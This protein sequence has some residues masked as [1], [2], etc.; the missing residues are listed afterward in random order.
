MPHKLEPL[1]TGGNPWL[2]AVSGILGK[3]VRQ[4]IEQNTVVEICKQP[5]SE[6]LRRRLLPAED[7]SFPLARQSSVPNAP[8]SLI[9]PVT[10]A[11]HTNPHYLDWGVLLGTPHF[12]ALLAGSSLSLCRQ[13]LA[14]E[15]L[16]G[17]KGV[18]DV[19]AGS[20]GHAPFSPKAAPAKTLS[21]VLAT[22]TVTADTLHFYNEETTGAA[23]NSITSRLPICLMDHMGRRKGV[24]PINQK[25]GVTAHKIGELFLGSQA[26]DHPCLRNTRSAPRSIFFLRGGITDATKPASLTPFPICSHP[27]DSV[28]PSTSY[29]LLPESVT[30]HAPSCL[31]PGEGPERGQLCSDLGFFVKRGGSC[32]EVSQIINKAELDLFAM[33][34][35]RR[36]K[37][38]ASTRSRVVK[39][40]PHLLQTLGSRHRG[41]I[42]PQGEARYMWTF[43]PAAQDQMYSIVSVG[44]V[45]TDLM[46]CMPPTLLRPGSSR[47]GSMIDSSQVSH[48][49]SRLL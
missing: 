45:K 24:S 8:V 2:C 21:G 23:A 4:F 30:E 46:D 40:H 20:T 29:E 49:S 36:G 26:D 5:L 19:G 3:N 25:A 12:K 14:I 27:Y 44:S 7:S 17:R 47:Y 18:W 39:A 6:A 32:R 10:A 13:T 38:N 1:I 42:F 37:V 34:M 43:H 15:W 48:S 9:F 31:S 16:S 11:L 28:Q 33:A 35:R 41:N 22:C